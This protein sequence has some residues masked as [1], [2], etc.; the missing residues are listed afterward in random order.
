MVV[1]LL[2][3]MVLTDSLVRVAVDHAENEHQ[4]PPPGPAPPPEN[5]LGV[6]GVILQQ[7]VS[8]PAA[9]TT[10]TTKCTYKHGDG[11]VVEGKKTKK[12]LYSQS[13]SLS[14]IKRTSFPLSSSLPLDVEMWDLNYPT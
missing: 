14:S 9:A 3:E 10:A 7:S 4:Q 8:Q 12:R 13:V 6:L 2:E 11:I 1:Q 5:L